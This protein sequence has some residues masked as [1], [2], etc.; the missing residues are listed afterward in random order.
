MFNKILKPNLLLY[1]SLLFGCLKKIF[2]LYTHL[3]TVDIVKQE[4]MYNLSDIWTLKLVILA[5]SIAQ[6]ALLNRI[7]SF[8]T[9]RTKS[10]LKYCFFVVREALNWRLCWWGSTTT[11]DQSE[12]GI[13]C[14]RLS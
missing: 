2:D 12:V 7:F 10:W 6:H 14:H 13:S 1:Q 11:H 3:F 9:N 5:L 8:V 4:M